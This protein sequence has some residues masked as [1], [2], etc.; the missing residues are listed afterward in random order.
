MFPGTAGRG[1]SPYGSGSV[2]PPL[3]G[4]GG[5]VGAVRIMWGQNRSFPNNAQVILL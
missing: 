1:V 3:R 4:A 5:T 2:T